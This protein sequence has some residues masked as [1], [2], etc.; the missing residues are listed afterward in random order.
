M[1]REKKLILYQDNEAF[2]RQHHKR[3]VSRRCQQ[4]L[5]VIADKKE[6]ETRRAKGKK[7][8]E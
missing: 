8:N 7:T 1:F 5:K 2:K 6:C 3:N 4:V